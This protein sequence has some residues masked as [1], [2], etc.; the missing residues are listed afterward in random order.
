MRIAVLAHGFSSWGGGIHFLRIVVDALS[1][2]GA[3]RD[4]QIFILNPG[5][6][7]LSALRACSRFF[8]DLRI[9]RRRAAI[10][11]QQLYTAREN[12]RLEFSELAG[13]VRIM[14]IDYGDFALTRALK[15]LNIDVVIPSVKP[16]GKGFPFPWVGY[17]YDFQHKYLTHLFTEAERFRRD[18]SFLQMLSEAPAAIVNAQ[19]VKNDALRFFPNSSSEIFVMPFAAAPRDDWFDGSRDIMSKYHLSTPF[20]MISN[21]FW[22][23]KDHATAFDAFRLIAPAVPELSLVCTGSIDDLRDPAY[24]PSLIENLARAGLA[25]RARILGMIQKRD[26][27]EIMKSAIA[28]LQPTLF[29]GGPGGGAAYDAISLGVPV[30][31]SDI[32]VNKELG[33]EPGVIFFKV[34]DAADLAEKM[35]DLLTTPTR[36][37]EPTQLIDEGHR[38]RIRCGAAL[39]EAI[40]FVQR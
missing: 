38:R 31:V 11:W 23:H 22:Q 21:Q 26:Q 7:P 16:L 34:G 36:S 35:R 17:L 24:F 20:F 19:A 25:D 30:I 8:K 1:A 6:G 33:D 3:Q 28:V 13:Q 12:V 10:S 14:Q 18:A 5:Y 15:S 4:L 32:A 29:E 39:L 27:I 40:D 37:R 9:S 2:V